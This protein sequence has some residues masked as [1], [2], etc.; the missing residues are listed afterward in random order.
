MFHQIRKAL[1]DPRTSLRGEVEVDETYI[2][3][4]LRNMHKENREKIHGRGTAGKIP[5]LG[6]MQRGGQVQAKVVKDSS[7]FTLL[8]EITANVEEGTAIITD[9]HGAY[10]GLKGLG[11]GHDVVP[12]NEGVYVIGKDIHTNTLEGF[13]SLLKRSIDGTYHHVTEKYLQAYVNE[14]AFRYSHRKDHRNLFWTM[15]DRIIGL[16]A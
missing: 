15:M 1:A 2:G 12:H 13:W 9:G 5:V 4:K 10:S 6:M 3:G 7:A 8:P 11:Y 14:Y 16:S